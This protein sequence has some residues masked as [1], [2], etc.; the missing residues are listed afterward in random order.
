MLTNEPMACIYELDSKYV[1][2]AGETIDIVTISDTHV[3]YRQ[4]Q[5]DGK[6]ISIGNSLIRLF[7]NK[8][9]GYTLVDDSALHSVWATQTGGSHYSRM[10]IQPSLFCRANDI[11][12]HEGCVIKRMCRHAFKAGAEDCIKA[13]DEI[14]AILE[15]DYGVRSKLIKD[16]IAYN[17]SMNAL[18]SNK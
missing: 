6:C 10:K 13:I 2:E 3:Q 18:R 17:A 15:E 16:D 14:R 5:P 9:K 1:N 11:Q 12:F 8:L 7:H 4:V